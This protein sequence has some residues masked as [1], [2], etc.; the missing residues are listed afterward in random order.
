MYGDGR[1]KNVALLPRHFQPR[2]SRSVSCINN[3][4]APSI[5]N[6]NTLLSSR[7]GLRGRGRGRGRGGFRGQHEDDPTAKDS[8]VQRTDDD[9]ADS[10]MS[11]VALGYL[12]DP[13]AEYFAPDKFARRYP[14]INRG[15]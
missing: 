12:D 3:M 4:T 2:G 7:G 14:I 15:L 10:R 8:T 6:L 11:V 9:A 13:F 5:P 1:Q